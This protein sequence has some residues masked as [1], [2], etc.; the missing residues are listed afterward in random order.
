MSHSVKFKNAFVEHDESFNGTINMQEANYDIFRDYLG[1]RD[2]K[3][4][5]G[6]RFSYKG[7][8]I[9][10][11]KLKEQINCENLITLTRISQID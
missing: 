1:F 6:V 4:F 5:D 10:T 2:F 7:I 3:N 9:V 11:I 8:R